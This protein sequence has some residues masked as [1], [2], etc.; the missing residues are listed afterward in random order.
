MISTYAIKKQQLEKG[1]FTIG[2]GKEVMLIMGSCRVAPYVEYLY[3]W[4]LVNDNRYTIHS[5]DPFNH[6]WNE[7]DER[8]DYMEAL[9]KLETHGG[10]LGML[11]SVDIF[12]HEHYKN[13]AMFN[14]D[15]TAE[16]NIYKYGIAPSI[17]VCIPSFN[18]HFI[19]FADI[20]QFDHE[21]RKRATQDFNVIGRLSG[22]TFQQL[23][24]MSLKNLDK[25]FE[26]CL[27]SDLPEL[28][29]VIKN[30]Y[31]TTRYWH[32]YNHVSR[33]FTLTVFSMINEKYLHL[34]IKD[35]FWQWIANDD[36]FG[37]SYTPLTYDDVKCHEYNWR[38]PVVSLKD[39]IM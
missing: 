12:L 19:M 21:M 18:D 17:D 22:S 10:L 8:V 26:R 39:K 3:Q 38:E 25:F 6:N 7:N 34:D 29:A 16:K 20:L 1:F 33:F 30:Q 5:I 4:N 27:K 32:T 28:A 37:N 15:K 31:K 35:K 9:E 24:A 11:K 36:M 2:S 14:C 13:A 23:E